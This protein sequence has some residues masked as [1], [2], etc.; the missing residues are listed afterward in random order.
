MINRR[1]LIRTM[2]GGVA[3]PL[4]PRISLGAPADRG[5]PRRVI[6]FLQNNGFEPGTCIPQGMT[7]SGSLAKVRLPEPLSPLEPYKD[8]MHILS[9]LHTRPA[10]SAYFGALGGYSGGNGVPPSASTIDH[11]LSKALPPTILPHLCIGMDSLESMES[12]PT[13]ATLSASGAG[14]PIFMH[15]NPNLLY[16]MLYGG[17]SQGDIREQHVAESRLFTELEK[18]AGERT[19]HLPDGEAQRYGQ[20]VQGFNDINSL[21]DQLGT[22]ADHLRKFAPK[23][24]ER[25]TKPQFETDWHDV[26]LDLGISALKAG[27]TNTLTIASGRGEVFGSWKGVDV[28]VQGHPLGHMK[29]AGNPIWTKIRQY[30]CRMLVKIMQEL[31]KVPEDGGT[32]MDHTL[33][34]YTS[35]NADKQ[36]TDGAAWP[37]VLLGNF[38]GRLKTGQFTQLGGK[39]P[40][41][42]L[43]ATLLHAATGRQYERFNMSPQLAAQHDQGDGPIKELLS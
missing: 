25:Y 35:N 38:D 37:V 34:V 17:I 5:G 28:E 6:F 29:Q 8:R 31:E 33:I 41:N 43:Y 30:N 2:A 14:Q 39:R 26:N 3:L 19:K 16:Q 27:I 4:L 36:H 40:V 32:M 23:V 18:L 42:A 15:S 12:K 13:I 1:E 9:G 24:D 20:F 7:R 11:E 10:H 21:R 22:I